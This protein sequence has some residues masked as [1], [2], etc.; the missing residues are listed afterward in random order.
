MANSNR[1]PENQV[2]DQEPKETAQPH[3]EAGQAEQPHAEAGQAA[4]QGG[5]VGGTEVPHA[6][7]GQAAEQAAGQAAL[8]SIKLHKGRTE[9]ESADVYVAVNG[10]RFQIQRGVEVKVPYFVKEVLDN[11]ERQDM[12][13]IAYREKLEQGFA[14]LK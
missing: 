6:Q 8:V 2:K 13:A 4:P 1:S 7:A 3:A 14:S 5:F 9:Q 11:S 12:A 10:R